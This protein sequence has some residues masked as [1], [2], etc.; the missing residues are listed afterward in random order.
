MIIT[1]DHGRGVTKRTWRGHGD[2]VPEAGEIWIAAMGP[3]TPATGEMK[4]QGQWHSAMIART[5]FQLLGMEYPDAK[6]EKVI[7]EMIK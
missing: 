1:T 5:I 2:E 3:D 6:A 4:V 7:Q